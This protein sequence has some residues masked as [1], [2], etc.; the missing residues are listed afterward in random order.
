MSR[1]F[2]VPVVL[3]LSLGLCAQKDLAAFGGAGQRSEAGM[4]VAHMQG[5]QFAG[6]AAAAFVTYG[7]PE[8]K[9]DYSEQVDSFTKGKI[10]R[11]GKDNWATLDNAT[12][13]TLNGKTIPAGIWY[14]A[15]ARDN[16]DGWTLVLVDPAKA[17][18]AGAAPFAP[19]KAP[20]THEVTMK[21]EM[22]QGE[23]AK[24][25]SIAFDKD[26]ANPTK[27]TL[28]IAWGDRKLTAPYELKVIGGA[29]TDAAGKTGETKGKD[30][31]KQKN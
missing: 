6:M 28:T 18:E 29:A 25:L 8:W 11:L 26:S 19:E 14:M 9:K 10:F 7:A 1:S 5:N 13:L 20:R 23:G 12:A 21:H 17:K 16:A 2:L 15:I 27:G 4:F 3:T 24:K 30:A 22:V 31:G